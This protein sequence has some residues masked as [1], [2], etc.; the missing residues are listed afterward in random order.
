MIAFKL[1]SKSAIMRVAVTILST[2]AKFNV[3]FA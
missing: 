2:P 1:E 3:D